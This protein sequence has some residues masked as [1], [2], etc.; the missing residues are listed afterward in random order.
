MTTPQQREERNRKIAT[1]VQMLR[2]NI[3]ALRATVVL[4]KPDMMIEIVN[5]M[6]KTIEEL[7]RLVRGDSN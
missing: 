4:D 7:T 5:E 3:S 6:D 2:A 1:A